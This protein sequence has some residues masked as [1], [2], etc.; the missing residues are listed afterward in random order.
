MKLTKEYYGYNLRLG[1]SGILDFSTHG[2]N[3]RE[4]VLGCATSI[5]AK[6]FPKYL[7]Y[8]DELKKTLKGYDLAKKVTPRLGAAMDAG[9]EV[10]A[11]TAGHKHERF[12]GEDNKKAMEMFFRE[13]AFSVHT[14]RVS[15]LREGEEWI[16]LEVILDDYD[17]EPYGRLVVSNDKDLILKTCGRNIEELVCVLRTEIAL[18]LLKKAYE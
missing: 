9:F 14:I 3:V 10:Y 2:T 7:G 13:W 17:R 18:E 8:P 12:S 6:L 15:R 4:T 16:K 5:V 1:I 11:E